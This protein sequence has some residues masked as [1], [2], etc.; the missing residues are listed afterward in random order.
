MKHFSE[1]EMFDIIQNKEKHPEYSELVQH[2][3][4]CENCR[5]E[6]R[7]IS[8]LIEELKSTNHYQIDDDFTNKILKKLNLLPQ[9]TYELFVFKTII[10]SLSILLISVLPYLFILF[11]NLSLTSTKV[12]SDKYSF[13]KNIS[14]II[15]NGVYYIKEFFR[16]IGK[17]NIIFISIFIIIFALFE[18]YQNRVVLKK[19]FKS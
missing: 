15:L 10:W 5:I 13:L 7:A 3:D 18:I 19:T 2:I 14:E 8:L 12:Q 6:Y 16:G 17:D 9:K 1:D 11:Y 4:S